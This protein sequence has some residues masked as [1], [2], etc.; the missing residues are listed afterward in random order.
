MRGKLIAEFAPDER[1]TSL[2]V[3]FCPPFARLPEVEAEAVNGPDVSVHVAQVLHNGARIEV[4]L[5]QAAAERINVS[6]EFFAQEP[7]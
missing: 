2:H 1:T 4:R 6:L 7:A 5:Q 3:A